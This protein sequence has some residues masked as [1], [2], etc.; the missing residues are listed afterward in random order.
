MNRVFD[1][2]ERIRALWKQLRETRRG[3]SEYE[4]LLKQI[5]ALSAEYQALIDVI[6]KA[7]GTDVKR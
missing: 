5:R 1:I 2:L 7:G 4:A 6:E 3:T